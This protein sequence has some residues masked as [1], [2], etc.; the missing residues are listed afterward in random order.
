[1]LKRF[2]GAVIAGV[3]ILGGWLYFRSSKPPVVTFARASRGKIESVVVTNGKVEPLEW[4]S[5]V[6]EAE[7]LIEKVLVVKGQSVKR[8]QPLAMLEARQ[9]RAD[10]AAA[11][12]RI[13]EAKATIQTLQGGGRP[14]DQAS[15]DAELKRAQVDLTQARRDLE[16]LERLAAKNAATKYEVQTA[17]DLVDRL[18]AQISSLQN[19]RT[20]LVNPADM[21]TAKARQNDA[22][23]AA[24]LARQQISL[25]TITAPIDGVV[26]QL[27]VKAGTYVA[28]GALIA[29]VGTISRV[30]AIVYVDEPELGRVRQGMAVTITWDALP[31]RTWNGVVDKPAT[32]IVPLGTRQVGEVTCLIDNPDAALLPGTNINASIESQVAA[33]VLT[34]PKETVRRE[35]GV[36]GVYVLDGSEIR[37]RT[38][39]TGISSVTRMETTSGL[40][41]GDWIALPSDT[42]LQDGM[43]VTPSRIEESPRP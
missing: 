13:S 3:I 18:A 42:P 2:A 24:R 8:G 25:A 38:I 29:N 11:E 17:R 43:A 27:D 30:K 35:G 5:A 34:I 1:M 23:A 39:K 36:P 14:A 37:W 33:N 16:S 28:P 41:E 19:R 12:A 7:G 26:Y 20:A 32:Q 22:E 6:A 10:L 9:A 21:A 40:K 31:A 4:A 15:I